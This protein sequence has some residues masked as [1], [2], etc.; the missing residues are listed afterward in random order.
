MY[1]AYAP[2]DPPAVPRPG[3]WRRFLGRTTDSALLMSLLSVLR[4]TGLLGPRPDDGFLSTYLFGGA[5]QVAW[6]Y[7]WLTTFGTTPGKS[8]WGMRLEV[9]GTLGREARIFQRCWRAWVFGCGLNLPIVGQL[10]QAAA[11]DKIKRTGLSPWDTDS[12][13]YLVMKG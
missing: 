2:F 6:E 4:T 13:T 9:P 11:G 8:L 3:H 10:V 12:Q 1:D 7:T 5:V